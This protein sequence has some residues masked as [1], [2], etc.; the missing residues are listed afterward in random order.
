MPVL[1]KI[2]AAG[3]DV[4][5]VDG[6]LEISPADELTD[7]QRTYLKS[8]KTEIIA[9]LVAE[10]ANDP[11]QTVTTALGVDEY[12]YPCHV[13]CYTPM[14]NPVKVMATD[15]DHEAFLLEMNPKPTEQPPCLP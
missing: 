14:G 10:A 4:A 8:H 2:K 9:E 13:T 3:F 15:A 12:A 6:Y 1:A 5:L 11:G 7:S